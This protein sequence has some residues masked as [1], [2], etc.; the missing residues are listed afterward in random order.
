MVFKKK[1][2]GD[3]P[4]VDE[5]GKRSGR[6]N[7]EAIIAIIAVLLSIFWRHDDK[8]SAFG[9]AIA[10]NAADIKNVKGDIGNFTSALNHLS[11]RIDRV[12]E[13]KK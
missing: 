11:E 8:S 10:A 12:L 2:E 1:R 4:E 13:A 6:F 9:E 7:W 5:T 3:T